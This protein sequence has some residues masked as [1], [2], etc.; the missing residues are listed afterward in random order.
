MKSLVQAVYRFFAQLG[1]FGLLGLG[2]LD[3][4]VLFL[5]MGN[6]ILLVA[7]TS[8]QPELMPFYVLMATAGSLLGCLFTDFV[9]RKGGEAGL[10]GRVPK[11]RLEYIQC[12]IRTHAAKALALAAVM[13]PP[14][15]FTP[16][17]AVAAASQYPRKKLL[18]VLA[19]ARAVRFLIEGALAIFFGRRLLRLAEHPLVE[20]I[21]V[22]VLAVSILGSAIS[23]AGWI[24]RSKRVRG[25]AGAV[26]DQ[27][28]AISHTGSG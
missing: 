11:R 10:E 22:T 2:A 23:I 4:S 26:S 6:D 28:S 20:G 3:S 13:P 19:G 9:S 1:G 27:A 21:V 18:A 16:V 17:V 7:L 5:P 25:K 14:F 8:R 24:R 12:K 15:P